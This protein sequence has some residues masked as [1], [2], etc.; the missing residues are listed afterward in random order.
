MAKRHKNKADS[1]I[2]GLD[3][4]PLIDV[5]F[6]LLIFFI[7]TANVAQNVFDLE[8]PK[9]DDGYKAEE[10]DIKENLVKLTL[11]ANGEYAI[12]EKKVLGYTAFKERVLAVYFKNSS[13]KF[14]I[15]AEN[16]LSVEKMM[17]FLTFLKSNNITKIDILLKK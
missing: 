8:L 14:L 10:R 7:L 9:A 17:E 2:V 3:L 12:E 6:I 4:T 13:T 16:T 11:F 15:I 1:G 5:V